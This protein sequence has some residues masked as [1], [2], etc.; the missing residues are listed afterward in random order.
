MPML[1]ITSALRTMLSARRWLAMAP[2]EAWRSS[3]PVAHSFAS[4]SRNSSAAP[5][6]AI[7]PSSGFSRKMTARKIGTQG[8]SNS[9]SEAGEPIQLRQ[10]ARSR[11]ASIR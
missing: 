11:S 8:T 2:V 5:P 10:A 7:Q 1:S 9:V 6:S 3:R 4:V